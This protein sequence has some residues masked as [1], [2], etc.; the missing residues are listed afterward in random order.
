MIRG[1]RGEQ[2]VAAA[3]LHPIQEGCVIEDMGV[4]LFN[5][6]AVSNFRPCG[7][8]RKTNVRAFDSIPLQDA[9]MPT[10]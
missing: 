8:P 3:V 9:Q 4:L 6:T 10:G 1:A 5:A 2:D 7:R